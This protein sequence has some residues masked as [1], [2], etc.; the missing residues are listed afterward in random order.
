VG[1]QKERK[2]KSVF[3]N[4]KLEQGQDPWQQFIQ[5]PPSSQLQRYVPVIPALGKLMQED[6][7]PR[8][9]WATQ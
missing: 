2:E 7:Q 9:N 6:L 8:L 1:K 4:N 5:R 3:N